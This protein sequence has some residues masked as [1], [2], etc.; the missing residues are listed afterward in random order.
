LCLYSPYL[1]GR[2]CGSIVSGNEKVLHVA[3]LDV[4][5]A[6]QLPSRSPESASEDGRRRDGDCCDRVVIKPSAEPVPPTS[7]LVGRR[8]SRGSSSAPFG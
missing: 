5:K 8:V 4:R 3:S 6:A 2:S 1:R 7:Y